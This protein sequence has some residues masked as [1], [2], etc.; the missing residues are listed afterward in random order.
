M[1]KLKTQPLKSN[2]RLLSA[3][4]FA[5]STAST[6]TGGGEGE[7]EGEDEGEGSIEGEDEGWG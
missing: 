2:Q 1:R 3:T 6:C 5:K 7:C 4:N